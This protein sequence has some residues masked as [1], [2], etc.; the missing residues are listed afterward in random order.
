MVTQ[1]IKQ[2]IINMKH[3]EFDNFYRLLMVELGISRHSS[4]ELQAMLILLADE[5][6][7]TKVLDKMGKAAIV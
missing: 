6:V 7:F 2:I 5:H 3:G 4:C 1:D